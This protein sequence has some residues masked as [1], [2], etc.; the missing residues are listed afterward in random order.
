MSN[1]EKLGLLNVLERLANGI[2][3][4]VGPHCEVV[5][6]DFS[7]LEHSAVIVAGNVSGRSPGAP[8]PDLDFI[9]NGLNSETPD[10]LN[11]RIEIGSRDL[12]SS[13]IWLRDDEGMSVGAV[14]INIDYFELNQ[15]HKILER[16]I[17][18]TKKE[19]PL[20]IQDTW[21]KDL[22]DLIQLSVSTFL[23]QEGITNIESM[24]Q[25]DKIRLI[26]TVEERGLFKLRGAT[27][28]LAQIMNVSRA[29]IYNYRA[30]VKKKNLNMD[31]T[32]L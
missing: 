32:A 7:D 9:S 19:P 4:V 8:I 26:E 6:H 31:L 10:Q 3:A 22:D 21:A 30:N 14:C 29:S 2:V 12:Q 11:Y 13:T 15:A 18:P 5:V 25:D 27:K 23:R 16:L 17:V 1:L 20:T 24:T 28:R